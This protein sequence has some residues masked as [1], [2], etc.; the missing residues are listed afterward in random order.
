MI[1]WLYNLGF[2]FGFSLM[3]PRFLWRM[4]RRGGYARN[5]LQRFGR[6]APETRAQLAEMKCDSIQGYFYSKP[7]PAGALK[8]FRARR[9]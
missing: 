5:F 3:L 1:W 6:Y 8:E 7:L 4:A 9:T 2:V